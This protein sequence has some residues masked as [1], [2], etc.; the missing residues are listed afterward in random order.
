MY[1]SYF[2]NGMLLYAARLNFIIH[3]LC[4][5]RKS[6]LSYNKGKALF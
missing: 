2:L 3:I 5:V 1:I 6:G 4:L